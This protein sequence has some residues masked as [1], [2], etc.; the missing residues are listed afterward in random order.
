MENNYTP[1]LLPILKWPSDEKLHEKSVDVISF[2]EELEHLAQDLF[3]TMKVGEGIGLAAPQTGN[4]INVIVIWIEPER[5]LAIV[6]PTIT[7]TSDDLYQFNEGCL[8]VPGYFENRKRP[9]KIVIECQD[10]KGNH[11]EYEFN[12]LY[13]FVI[14]HEIDHLNGKLFVDGA[15]LL[16]KERIRAKMKKVARRK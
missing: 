2:D 3:H 15:S 9:A 1:K 8:S 16:K 5:P 14:Q 4:M 12:G 10:L 13:A 7:E 6:N 11:H